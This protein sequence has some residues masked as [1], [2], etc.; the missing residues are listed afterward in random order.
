[1]LLGVNLAIY[2]A[3]AI[4]GG[5]AASFPTRLLVAWGALVSN[6][7]GWRLF[8]ATFLHVSALPLPRT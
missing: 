3:M 8:T 4:D 7:E 2:V 5:R 1:V 6:G